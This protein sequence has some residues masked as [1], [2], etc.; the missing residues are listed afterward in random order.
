MPSTRRG[1]VLNDSLSPIK[2]KDT[3]LVHT[4]PVRVETDFNGM[5]DFVSLN[6]ILTTIGD[7]GIALG[8]LGWSLEGREEG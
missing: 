5:S 1:G 3:F 7:I 8:K 4:N 2:F 6:F